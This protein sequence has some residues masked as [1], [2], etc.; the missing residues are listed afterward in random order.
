[1]TKYQIKQLEGKANWLNWKGRVSILLRGSSD[2]LDVVEGRLRKPD[3]PSDGATEA[4]VTAYQT[5]LSKYQKADCNAMII[6]S[7][8]MSE[9]TYERV[10]SITSARDTWLE[11]HRLYDGVQDDRAYDLCMQFFGYKMSAGDDIATHIAKLKNIWKDLKV[12]IEKDV[13][14]NLLLMCRI[15]ETLP[16][17]YFAFASSWRM[18]SKVE[19]T[20]ENLTDQLCSY[21]RA[22]AGKTEINQQEALLAKASNVK[23]PKH[24]NQVRVKK[25]VKSSLLCHY[26]RSPE[27]FIKECGKWIADGRPRKPENS[28]AMNANSVSMY[29]VD[30]SAFAVSD[31]RNPDEWFVD[32]GAT[33]HLTFRNDI[34]QSFER[35][36]IPLKLQVADGNTI[37]ALGKGIVQL[38][39]TVDGKSIEVNLQD[40]WYVPKLNR[41]LFSVLAAQ[42]KLENSCFVSTKFKCHLEV[43]GKKVLAGERKQNG[44]LFRLVAETKFTSE[45][46]IADACTAEVCAINKENVLQLYHER[47]GHQNKRHVKTVIKREMNIDVDLDSEIC[48]GCV[49]GKAHRLKF[50]TRVKATRPGERIHADVCGPFCYSFSKCRYFVLFKDDYSSFR[51]VYFMKEKSEVQEKLKFLLKNIRTA[52]YVVSEF[53][54]DNGGEFDNAEVRKTLLESGIRQRLIMPYTPEQNGCSERENR[55]LVEAARTMRLAH[56]ELPQALWAELINTAAYILNRTGTSSVEGK[57]PYELWYNK[58]PQ[59]KHLRVIG[60]T[61]Y[62]HIPAQCRK[63]MDSKAVKGVLVGYEGDDGYRIYVQEGNKSYRSRD[64][65]FDETPL[66]SSSRDWTAIPHNEE[67]EKEVE[68]QQEN[69]EANDDV[70]PESENDEEKDEIGINENQIDQTHQ[71][72]LR[73]RKCIQRP[74]NLN[75]YVMSVEELMTDLKEPETYE[76]AT[77]DRCADEWR[78][79]MKSEIQSLKENDT[80]ELVD[81]PTGKK[82]IPCK[83]VFKLKNNPDGSIERY[84]ARLV[85][86]GYSQKKGI[87]YSDTFSPV[88]RSSTVRTLLSVAAK[89]K[90]HLM[91]FDVSTAFLYGRLEEEIFMEQPEGFTENSEKVCKLKRSLYGLKQAPRCW[92]KRFKDFLISHEF[93]SSDADP[94]LF[95]RKRNSRKILIGLFV[96]DGIVASTDKS[97][98]EKFQRELEAEFRITAKPATYFLG[99]E[100]HQQSDGSIKISQGAYTRKLLDQFGM[101]N[102]RPCPTPIIKSEKEIEPGESQSEQLK[103][104]YRSAVGALMYLMTGTRPDIAY[105][106]SVVSRKLE[107]PSKSDVVQVKRIFRYLRGTLDDG[108]TYKPDENKN[109]LI[110]YSDADHGGD[111]ATGR[112]TSGVVCIYSGGAIS[113]Q[114]QRQATVAISTTEAEVVAASEAAREVV[115]LKR[116]L[117]DITNF[118]EIPEIYVDNEAAIR[119]AQNPE[120]HRRTKHIEIR[121]FFIREKVTNGEIVVSKISSEFQVADA[122]TKALPRPKLLTL[123]QT[124]GLG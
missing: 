39:A 28:R 57:S 59:I 38:Q 109:S 124:V 113:W 33:C 105:A 56:G 97:E 87:D 35:F 58:K 29:A 75:D 116:L 5:S 92:N 44:G 32:N 88:V 42:D 96:D 103:F 43:G 50:G 120:L 31:S 48:E 91:Q 37:E 21:E 89:E 121:H 3:E 83:W 107:N 86:K 122:L 22:L 73:D 111:K 99:I 10:R 49:Y 47:F 77:N 68:V 63:K 1:M 108:I 17:E 34:F 24:K 60:C 16:R 55:T 54:S 52:G 123:M 51:F 98:L 2:A 80:W 100:I 119:L 94:C 66:C 4:Q 30:N 6:L 95:I 15:V 102:C 8:N 71:M 76:E 12:E 115:W 106:V 78:N 25:N 81:R 70:N 61:A 19:R 45:S 13:N 65:V 90:L 79:A 53:L 26:C 46:Y 64:V 93:K 110:C 7:S 41:N 114:S 14:K 72:Q 117:S 101:S 69:A 84:K 67:S 36:C 118:S 20:V 9:E 104:P 11:L 40:V 85:V 23:S 18:L 82:V 27:H 74:A 112:S 62:V